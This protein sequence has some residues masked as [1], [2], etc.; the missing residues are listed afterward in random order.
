MCVHVSVYV[1][2][3]VCEHACLYVHMFGLH[4]CVSVSIC[5]Y[6]G[7]HTWVY[8][9]VYMCVSLHVYMYAYVC[10]CERECQD[11]KIQTL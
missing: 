4:V 11:A 7:E 9:H 5:A 2:A 8:V 10:V 6:V 3:C 1:I